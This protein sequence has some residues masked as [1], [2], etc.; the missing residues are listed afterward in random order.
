MTHVQNESGA[1]QSVTLT[2]Q[3]VDS[4]STV[5]LTQTSAQTIDAGKDFVFDQTGT[6]NSPH[7]WYPAAST[8]GKPYLYKVY[9][10]VKVNGAT[11]DVFQSPL[12][13]R[14]ITWDNNGLPVINGHPHQLWGVGSRYD[15]PALATAVPEE[16]QWRDA[17]ICAE[18]GG[19]LWRPGHSTGSPEFTAACDA[20][21]I[22]LM[23]PSGDLEG[24]FSTAAVS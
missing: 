5:V 9:H 13:I 2:T 17:K 16:Q 21:G 14:T 10:I 24:N 12:G 3:V 20:Y 7:L 8:Y 4:S 19:R 22:M 15:Y 18:Y 23:Q 1:S 6:V 11:V